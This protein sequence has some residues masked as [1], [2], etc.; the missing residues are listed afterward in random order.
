MS[1]QGLRV[2]KAP[3]SNPKL[4]GDLSGHN[5]FS[6]YREV[7]V[8]CGD[9]KWLDNGCYAQSGNVAL[10]Q[11]GR[12]S[13]EDG[14]IFLRELER[15]PHGAIMRLHVSGDFMYNGVLDR[16][17]LAAVIQGARMRPDITFYG[18]THVWRHINRSEWQFPRNFTLNASCDDADAY[19][20][21][22]AAGWDATTVVPD[23]TAWKRKGNVVVCP[24]QTSGMSCIECKLCMKSERKLTVAFIAHGTGK[25]KVSRLVEGVEL[26]ML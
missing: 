3:T 4:V 16:E 13:T 8:T 18:Y 11:R 15:I 2:T 9:C 1:N 19:R 26:P 5:M 20:E 17:Y 21:A 22:R 10:H 6:T 23:G 24:A 7:G 25:K 12:S 14:A